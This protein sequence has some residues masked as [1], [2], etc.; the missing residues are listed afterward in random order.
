[1]AGGDALTVDDLVQDRVHRPGRD[2]ARIEQLDR[3][4]RQVARVLPRLQ[5]GGH[6]RWDVDDLG[7]DAPAPDLDDADTG[8]HLAP[9]PRDDDDA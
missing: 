4:G 2:L 3:A 1:M 6:E 5:A 8:D 7:A 9:R